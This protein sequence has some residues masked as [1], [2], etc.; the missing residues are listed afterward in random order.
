MFAARTTR[1][2]IFALAQGTS[3]L[4]LRVGRGRADD[5]CR[6]GARPDA[7]L[8]PDWVDLDAWNPVPTT[9][10]WLATLRELAALARAA[11]D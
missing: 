2:R 9:D 11:A 8:G 4:R 6:R 10:S 5:A 3:L 1:G 7:E